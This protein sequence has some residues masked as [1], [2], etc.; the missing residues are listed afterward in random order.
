[1]RPSVII[2]ALGT[3]FVSLLMSGTSSAM[4]APAPVEPPG[5]AYSS[6]R[7]LYATDRQETKDVGVRRRYSGQRSI[8]GKLVYGVCDVTIPRA[9]ELGQLEDATSYTVLD[10]E[11]H[12]IVQ[13]IE[14]LD[15][16][17]FFRLLNNES[18][19]R[20][21][22]EILVFIHGFNVNFYDA[23]RRT[24]Q[25]AYD[26]KFQG[27][28]ILYSWPS[29]GALSQYVA[30]IDGADWSATHL[31]EFLLTLST[32][33]EHKRIHIIA[34]SM[35][36]RVLMRALESLSGQHIGKRFNQVILAA[37]DIDAGIFIDLARALSETA[38]RITLYASS[39]D[40]ALMLAR[41]LRIG[42]PRA[43]E[44]YPMPFIASGVDT[45]DASRTDSSL[46]GRLYSIG[47]DYYATS[48]TIMGDLFL[49]LR[50][51]SPPG[52]RFGIIPKWAGTTEN[53]REY[54][55]LLP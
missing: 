1:M 24:A 48:R 30:D 45:I 54:W 47:H 10:V 28:P 35:G 8:T 42:M 44:S 33:S 46:F 32:Q 6:I 11:K 37:P 12:I 17:G 36:S 34:H 40:R 26:L 22:D 29:H 2:R 16:S 43:G 20:H 4:W 49:L 19:R 13:K 51:E 41:S 5:T 27:V 52:E 9:H 39:N 50:Y 38:R 7:V 53:A 31:K 18:R 3:A 15:S 23:V 14:G 21:S 25:M 55:Q